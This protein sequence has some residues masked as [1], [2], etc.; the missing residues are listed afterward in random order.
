MRYRIALLV[1]LAACAPSAPSPVE[2]PAP[3][4]VDD[5]MPP[6]RPGDPPP[7]AIEWLAYKLKNGGPVPKDLDRALAMPAAKPSSKETAHDDLTRADLVLAETRGEASPKVVQLINDA[8]EAAM[9]GMLDLAD[10]LVAQKRYAFAAVR[11]N[12]AV[13]TIAQSELRDKATA[14]LAAIAAAGAAF[15]VN[16]AAALPLGFRKAFMLAQ[17]AAL[18]GANKLAYDAI[19]KTL[20]AQWEGYSLKAAWSGNCDQ[21]AP[22]MDF[23]TG[24]EPLTIQIN[25]QCTIEDKHFQRTETATYKA[26]GHVKKTVMKKTQVLDGGTHQEDCT[27]TH[28]VAGSGIQKICTVANTT[29]HTVEVPEEVDVIE[30]V[31]KTKPYVVDVH[32]VLVEVH[33]EVTFQVPGGAPH[34]IAVEDKREP[35]DTSY[36]YTVDGENERD[37]V[38]KIEKP[39]S[40]SVRLEHVLYD[41]GQELTR[42]IQTKILAMT[43]A[44]RTASAKAD[45]RAAEA[46]DDQAAAAEAYLRALLIDQ[47][48]MDD[49]SEWSERELGLPSSAAGFLLVTRPELWH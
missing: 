4:A 14:R 23:I 48:S 9:I 28:G 44:E 39:K 35:E 7:T 22:H 45:G 32:S 40:Q 38:R 6:R 13:H 8:K 20:R 10:D 46:R 25:G 49:R 33:A 43:V 11:L 37:P 15:Y 34:T 3:V 30:P 18:D 41:S 47:N 42:Q 2:H 17:A 31:E 12:W 24:G 21:L 36:S 29:T 1:A 19:L 27:A 26:P 5:D 16:A